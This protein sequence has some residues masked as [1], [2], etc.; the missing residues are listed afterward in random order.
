MKQFRL[1]NRRWSQIGLSTLGNVIWDRGYPSTL[2]VTPAAQNL[3]RC[4]TLAKSALQEH[5]TELVL[6]LDTH[7]KRHGIPIRSSNR[8]LIHHCLGLMLGMT[9]FECI[10]FDTTLPSEIQG[11]SQPRIDVRLESIFKE[12]T[13]SLVRIYEHLASTSPKLA[14]LFHIHVDMLYSPMIGSS[15]LLQLVTN[16]QVEEQET[17]ED[18]V[19][20]HSEDWR[21]IISTAPSVSVLTVCCLTARKTIVR[22]TVTYFTFTLF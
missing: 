11:M 1:V 12:Y 10:R 5:F 17:F 4:C 8:R 22:P 15:R 19:D 14:L 13:S 16:L 7:F 21:S 18:H 2:I 3:Q 6:K 20:H 9:N